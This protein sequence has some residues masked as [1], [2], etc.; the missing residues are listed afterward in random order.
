MDRK[1]VI[2][3]SLIT[4]FLLVSLGIV[5]SNI[6][7]S[8]NLFTKAQAQAVDLSLISREE[9]VSV[10]EEVR[11]NVFMNTNE[12]QNQ[13]L[14]VSAAEIH[15]AYDLQSFEAT[16][17]VA[18]DFLPVV[19]PACDGCVAGPLLTPGKAVI[20]LGSNPDSPSHGTGILAVLKLKA[21][22]KPGANEII[23]DSGT[24]V[25]AVGHDSDMTGTLSSTSVT[26]ETGPTPTPTSAPTP[27]KP[28]AP[29][30]TP[31]QPP[32]VTPTPVPAIP[33]DVNGDGSVN[34]LD[35][36]L[37]SNAFGTSN[38]DADFNSDGIVNILDF[39]ILSNNFGRVG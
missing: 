9:T 21:L 1:Q 12:D 8:L 38:P 37:L 4:L 31:T 13:I 22:N 20:I 6:E 39:Q 2:T 18:K 11:V 24:Q 3:F 36:T 30:P 5:V 32:T 14:S 28:P 10:G 7:K 26:I 17:F 15:I 27:T 34:I 16:A 19:L 29:T 23:F 35:Y 25:A 33:G